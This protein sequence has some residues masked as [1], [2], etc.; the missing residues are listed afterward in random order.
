MIVGTPREIKDNEYRV[1]LVPAGV[2][3]LAKAGHTVLIERSAGVGTGISDEEYRH[4]GAEIVGGA[5]EVYSRSDMIVKVKEPLPPEYPLI[6]RGQMV[7]TFFHFAASEQLTRAMIEA[8]GICVAYETIQLADG[9]L[10]LLTPMSEVAG[11]MAVQ[12][13]AEYLERPMRG[14]GILLAG[15]PGVSPANVLI[16]G[17]GVV[18]ANA[19]KIAAGMGAN[20]TIMDV[21]LERLRYLDDVMPK[22]VTTLFSDSYSICDRIREADLLIGAVLLKG[23]RAPV[24]VTQEMLKLM[25]PGAVIVDVAVDQGGCIET[26]RPTTH[27]EPTYIVEGVVH[28]AVANMPGAVPVTSTYALTN[29][30]LPYVLRLANE[31]FPGAFRADP[32]LREGLNVVGGKVIL[33]ELT[34]QFGLPATCAEEVLA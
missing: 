21:N 3:L 12:E 14:R 6:R 2:E 8:G 29:E 31:G 26:I 16:L 33:R 23:A 1:G 13:G 27:S 34:D 32:A 15:V 18:G 28:Y 4:A 30:T 17:G 10:P 11:R 25:K 24:L 5:E 22:N 9:S 20:V 19:A 7:F